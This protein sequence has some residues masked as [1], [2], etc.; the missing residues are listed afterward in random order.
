MNFNTSRNPNHSKIFLKNLFCW[1]LDVSLTTTNIL[2]F[3]YYPP[4][5]SKLCQLYVTFFPA[6]HM[7]TILKD[8]KHKW[9]YRSR[10]YLFLFFLFGFIHQ[11]KYQTKIPVETQL[12]VGNILI[13]LTTTLFQTSQIQASYAC[14]FVVNNNRITMIQRRTDNS[15]MSLIFIRKILNIDLF[16]KGHVIMFIAMFKLI[17]LMFRSALIVTQ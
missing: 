6:N 10:K 16:L 4:L 14:A 11:I 7:A 2:L 8:I 1:L 17:S 13:P 12:S 9:T 3:P 15:F 5:P